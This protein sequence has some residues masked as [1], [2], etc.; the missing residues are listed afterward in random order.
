MVIKGI[1]Q[2]QLQEIRRVQE[3]F[4]GLAG[5][6]MSIEPID[7]GRINK[8]YKVAISFEGAGFKA[9][10]FRAIN[11]HVFKNFVAMMNNTQIITEHIRNKGETTLYF[12]PV[13]GELTCESPTVYF[14][15]QTQKYWTVCDY[16]ES[17]TKNTPESEA[18]FLALGRMIGKFSLQ[19][20][21]LPKEKFEQI[22]ETIPDFHNTPARFKT[23]EGILAD[24]EYK[25]SKTCMEEITFL[26][27]RSYRADAI[28]H[29]LERGKIPKRVSHNDTKLNNVLFDTY[30]GLEKTIIDLDTTMPGTVLYDLGD[31][32]RYA[33]NTESEES[34]EAE[35]VHFDSQKFA[36]LVKGLLTTMKEVIT[37]REVDM[38]VDA[39]WIITYEQALRFLTDY[40][41]G[42]KYFSNLVP[43]ENGRMY[44]RETKNLER[45]RVQIALLQSIEEQYCELTQMV[46]T[47]WNQIQN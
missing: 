1:S 47:I 8:T 22:V 25:R 38:L 18:D 17:R 37:Q 32:A 3:H 29:P 20:S 28:T 5:K 15:A 41:D 9:F 35:K 33:C 13:I 34:V 4:E 42:D 12:H 39:A 2:E 43:D 6:I 30:T 7:N 44:N 26:V 16:I 27:L 14:D 11:T 19:L 21:D 40:L 36:Y 24:D 10:I 46:G 45:A 23:F 31:A